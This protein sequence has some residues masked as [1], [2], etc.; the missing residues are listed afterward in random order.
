MDVTALRGYIERRHLRVLRD[1]LNNEEFYLA[2][3][4]EVYPEDIIP[5]E[6]E[7]E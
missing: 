7:E 1:E 5:K 2:G 6:G 4:Q 3:N